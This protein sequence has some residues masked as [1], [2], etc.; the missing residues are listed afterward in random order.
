MPTDDQVVRRLKDAPWRKPLTIKPAF[1]EAGRD[2][3]L[4]NDARA[5]LASICVAPMPEHNY[6]PIAPADM[7]PPSTGIAAPVM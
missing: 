6:A 3:A 4:A 5:A 1:A 2:A 7:K